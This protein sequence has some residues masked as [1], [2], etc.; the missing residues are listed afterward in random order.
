M[1]T[2]TQK[3]RSKKHF[4]KIVQVSIFLFFVKRALEISITIR[5]TKRYVRSSKWDRAEKSKFL[6][7]KGRR[8]EDVGSDR[9]PR[10]DWLRWPLPGQTPPDLS[11]AHL[12]CHWL[13]GRHFLPSYSHSSPPLL[14]PM[15]NL[16]SSIA[17]ISITKLIKSIVERP[18]T[19]CATVQT[20]ETECL[21]Y[22]TRMRITQERRK[23]EKEKRE[24][25]KQMP[26]CSHAAAASSAGP[27][28]A[29]T[30]TGPSVHSSSLK[31]DTEKEK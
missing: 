13:D 31:Q 20:W 26:H 10:L 14:S 6:K 1:G 30:S 17:Y 16:S 11:H 12:V 3:F 22:P 8:I 9:I 7:E 25:K 19:R 15:L 27:Q 24:K 29:K 21:A 4:N 28:C 5:I 2:D 23:G 18:V